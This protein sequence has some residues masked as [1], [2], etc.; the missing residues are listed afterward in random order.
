MQ[1]LLYVPQASNTGR[2]KKSEPDNHLRKLYADTLYPVKGR[3]QR[4]NG[5]LIFSRENLGPRTNASD[6]YFLEFELTWSF[7]RIEKTFDCGRGRR[8][9]PGFLYCDSDYR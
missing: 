6:F 9:Y 8:V 4:S 7:K 3:N 2:G 1:R 5:K